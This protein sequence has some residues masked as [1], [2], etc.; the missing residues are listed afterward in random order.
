MEFF[1]GLI[2][3]AGKKIL[4]L[5]WAKTALPAFWLSLRCKI[6]LV[7]PQM[8]RYIYQSSPVKRLTGIAATST[9][10]D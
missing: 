7:R 10:C 4:P 6:V 2:G 9:I 8:T 5:V 1:T 3:G